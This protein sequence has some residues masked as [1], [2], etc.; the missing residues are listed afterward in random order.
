MRDRVLA[1]WASRRALDGHFLKNIVLF[2]ICCFINCPFEQVLQYSAIW[3]PTFWHLAKS[4]IRD[5]PWIRFL[6][7]LILL[8]RNYDLFR[9]H[10]NLEPMAWADFSN[11]K[12]LVFSPESVILLVSFEKYELFHFTWF[13]SP[14][15]LKIL[16]NKF[17]F[18]SLQSTCFCT[19]Q[20]GRI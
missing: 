5:T 12:E 19:Y 17:R 11:L 9:E 10:Q 14:S 8:T 4:L 1:R 7:E 13:I 18:D 2:L 3:T 20:T 6:Q 16:G 15:H